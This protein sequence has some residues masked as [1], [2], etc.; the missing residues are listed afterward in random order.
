MIKDIGNAKN[1]NVTCIEVI[2]IQRKKEAE[3]IFITISHFFTE[4]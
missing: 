4:T 1:L 3:G 2:I